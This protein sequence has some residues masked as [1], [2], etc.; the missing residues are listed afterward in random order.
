MRDQV[1]QYQK[2]YT[3]YKSIQDFFKMIQ[4]DM[5]VIFKNIINVIFE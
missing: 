4:I 3:F 1:V 5:I 2:I